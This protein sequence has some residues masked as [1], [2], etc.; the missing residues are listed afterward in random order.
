MKPSISSTDRYIL[1]LPRLHFKHAILL[2]LLV[3]SETEHCLN[4][5]KMSAAAASCRLQGSLNF[6]IRKYCHLL[7]VWYTNTA[8][9]VSTRHPS[10]LKKLSKHCGVCQSHVISY[11]EGYLLPTKRCK[12]SLNGNRGSLNQRF[13]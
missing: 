9:V 8:Q 4:N 2:I 12:T 1:H 13:S 3:S 7:G 5:K 10:S 6:K 11:T